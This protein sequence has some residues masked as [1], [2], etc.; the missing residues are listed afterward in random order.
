MAFAGGHDG[1]RDSIV[2]PPL[3][4][5]AGDLI[6]RGVGGVSLNDL[7]YVAFETLMGCAERLDGKFRGEWDE[8]VVGLRGHASSGV[9]GDRC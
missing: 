2:F 7:E 4:L 1:D 8:R 3:A 9:D 5:S 6:Q